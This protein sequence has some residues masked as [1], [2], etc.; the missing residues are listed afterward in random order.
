MRVNNYNKEILIWGI[1]R[2]GFQ[3]DD[4]L[5]R[6][7]YVVDWLEEVKLP[8]LKQLEA[9]AK[10]IHLPFG[11]LFLPQPP[12]ENIDFPFFRSNGE[13]AQ[14]SLNVFDTIQIIENRQEWLKEYLLDNGNHP[15]DYVG[16][17]TINDNSIQVA[18]D[19]RHVLNI[20]NLWANRCNTWEEALNYLSKIIEDIGI[21]TT[22]NGVVG[23]QTKRK[24]PVEECRGFVLVDEIVPFMFINN[25]DTK[26][27]Q[28]FTIA[29]ELAH[30]WVGRS[31]GFDFRNLQP[32]NDATEL[33]CDSVAAEFLVPEELFREQWARTHDFT[34]LNRFF[35]VSPIVVARRALDLGYITRES[36]FQFYNDYIQQEFHKKGGSTGGD[37][38]ATAK[39]RISPTFAAYINNGVKTG[40]LL[41]RDAYKLTGIHGDT[42]TTFINRIFL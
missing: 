15:L 2:A 23:N 32:A 1:E 17:F 19:I 35:K 4:F 6:E 21:I 26:A 38:Y 37:F 3:L 24:I 9:I 29:H 40:R 39:K 8:T 11:Y 13:T 42:F 25:S 27:A 5:Y 33:F 16:R 41:Y 36:F 28:V 31:A 20:D 10:K 7:S 22:F 34:Q 12:Q 14:I 30:V 18:N